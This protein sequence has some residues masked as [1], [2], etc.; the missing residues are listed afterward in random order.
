MYRILQT[1]VGTTQEALSSETTRVYGFNRSGPN[2]SLAM[3]EAIDILKETGRIEEIE[4]KLRV[5]K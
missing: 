4:G 5:K 2:I 3:S 1:C